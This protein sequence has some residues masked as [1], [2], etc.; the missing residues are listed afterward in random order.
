MQLYNNKLQHTSSMSTGM[1]HALNC[2]V[3]VTIILCDYSIRVVHLNVL[4]EYIYII[5][6][7]NK[8]DCFLKI[9]KTPRATPANNSMYAVY[10]SILLVELYNGKSVWQKIFMNFTFC[11]PFLIFSSR[12]FHHLAITTSMI[13]RKPFITKVLLKLLCLFW[14][15][16]YT[17]ECTHTSQIWLGYISHIT[18]LAMFAL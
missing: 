11:W 2:K 4:L 17:H 16:T 6:Q 15:S 8:P 5:R 7:F 10:C 18:I 14:P 12:I 3:A 13:F 1:I 9:S